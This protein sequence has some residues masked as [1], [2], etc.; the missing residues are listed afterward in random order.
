MPPFPRQVVDGC[1]RVARGSEYIVKKEVTREDRGTVVQGGQNGEIQTKTVIAIVGAIVCFAILLLGF[2]W[3]AR[4]PRALPGPGGD[5]RS[6]RPHLRWRC[7]D[8][9][10]WFFLRRARNPARPPHPAAEVPTVVHRP[11]SRLP[12][13]GPHAHVT[14]ETLDNFRSGAFELDSQIGDFMVRH[15]GRT[16]LVGEDGTVTDVEGG[17]AEKTEKLEDVI[18]TTTFHAGG[19]GRA[20]D[21]RARSMNVVGNGGLDAAGYD[22]V[23]TTTARL[24]STQ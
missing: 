23:D 21:D 7:C 16:G 24:E 13:V 17:I 3:V 20:Q 10:Q 1:T 11:A 15:A 12:H 9:S 18:V 4:K 19:D 2:W 8:F 14:E 5:R 22:T 6:N